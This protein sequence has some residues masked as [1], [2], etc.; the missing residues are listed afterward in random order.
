M[1]C[2]SIT[3]NFLKLQSRIEKQAFQDMELLCKYL[4]FIE[5]EYEKHKL[6]SR[7]EK[8]AFQGMVIVTRHAALLEL[9]KQLVAIPRRKAGISSFSVK[10]VSNVLL[11]LLQSR[12]EKQAFQEK[13]ASHCIP[14]ATSIVFFEYK[15][16]IAQNYKNS[17]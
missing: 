8:Q 9:L 1:V 12:V 7:V 2:K 11:Y 10:D 3:T 13:W 14:M 5:T 4:K 17:S 6:Q 15:Q 16:K